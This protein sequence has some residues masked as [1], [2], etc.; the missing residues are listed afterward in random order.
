MKSVLGRQLRAMATD[1]CKLL[2]QFAVALAREKLP[3]PAMQSIDL[4]RLPAESAIR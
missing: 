2:N 1:P 4:K 3:A